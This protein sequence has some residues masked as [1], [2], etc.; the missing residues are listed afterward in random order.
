MSTKEQTEQKTKASTSGIFLSEA[1]E[2]QF[3]AELA[4]T[5]E[6]EHRLIEELNEAFP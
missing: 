1:A 3:F 5:L 4:E 6:M 2:R